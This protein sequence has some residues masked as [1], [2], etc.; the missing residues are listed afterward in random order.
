MTFREVNDK[1]IFRFWYGFFVILIVFRFLHEKGESVG[2]GAGA[3]FF[4]ALCYFFATIYG[5]ITKTD[6]M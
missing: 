4:S 5:S 2:W 6:L 1:I 3:F